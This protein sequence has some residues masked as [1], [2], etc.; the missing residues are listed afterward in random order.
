MLAPRLATNTG[1]KLVEEKKIVDGIV[2]PAVLFK[3]G[4]IRK[5][6]APFKI[7]GEGELKSKLNIE[8]NAFSE[9]AKQKIEAAGGTIKTIDD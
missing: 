8:A 7:L 5:A 1:L 6:A 2:N 3:T 9:T 4:A